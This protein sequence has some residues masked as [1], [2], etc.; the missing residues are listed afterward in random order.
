MRTGTARSLMLLCSTIA[1]CGG[2]GERCATD[3]AC[4]SGF[5]KA[6][7]TCGPAPVDGGGDDAADATPDATPSSCTPDHDG[8][9]T[10]A[11]LPFAP[12]RTATFRVALD[13]TWSTAGQPEAGDLRRWDLSGALAGDADQALTLA[14]P[15]G[16]WW[17]A[18]FPGA[19]Y[20][21]RL[22][23]ES[24]LSGVF[25]V[26]GASLAL[27]GVVSPDDGLYKTE[28]SYDPP[29]TILGLP[30]S[31]G[32]T[33]AT[34][35]TVSGT[36]NGVIV[37]YTERYDSSVDQAGTLVTPYGEFPVVRVVTDLTRTS[38]LATLD[39]RRTFTWVAE[40]FGPV[41]TATSQSFASGDEL[42]DLAELRR[43][44]P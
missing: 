28:L 9:I 26:G 31:R 39:T 10:L 34:T 20:A 41:A 15:G 33:W 24:D 2:D 29:A 35:S 42:S 13:V 14:A 8:T 5:C 3:R 16:A 30:L 17:A 12:G 4:A 27:L 32:T 37:A 25:A 44:A 36:A 19:T 1:A 40:C 43:I 11:E 7:G 18:A 21:T 22:S 23:A 38:G 6:D